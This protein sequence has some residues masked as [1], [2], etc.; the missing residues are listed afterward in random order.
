MMPERLFKIDK[1]E[2]VSLTDDKLGNLSYSL[3]GATARIK[4][5]DWQSEIMTIGKH[6][7]ST[8]T[9]NK[10]MMYSC[11][12]DYGDFLENKFEFLWKSALH[13]PYP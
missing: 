7:G 12:T 4:F 8:I 10:K 3:T 13:L 9:F 2:K 1:G 11:K 5:V 6:T